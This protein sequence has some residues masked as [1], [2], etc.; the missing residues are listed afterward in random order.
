[1]KDL[2]ITGK[3]L[4]KNT[5]LNFFGQALPALVGLITL[6][7]IIKGLG[8][9]RFGVFSLAWV[10][11]GY[12]TIFD[13][14]LG[15]ATTK[16]VAEAL[17]KGEAKLVPDIV[18][19]AAITQAIFGVLGSLV[20]A[21]TTPLLVDQILSIP[22]DLTQEA[23]HAFYVVALIVPLILISNSFSGALDASQRFDLV[24]IVRLPSSTLTFILP[25][26]GTFLGFKLPGVFLLILLLRILTLSALVTFNYR[27]FPNFSQFS[28]SMQ[29]FSKLFTFGRWMLVSIVVGPILV[30][31]DRFFIGSLVSITAV[32]YYTVPYEAVTRLWI[33]PASL[34]MTLFPAFGALHGIKDRKNLEILLL[35]S[36]QYVLLC[37][38]PVV[39]V[40]VLYAREILEI[41][42]GSEFAARGTVAMQVLAVGVLVNSLA[43]AALA[44]LQG[45][46]R[47]DLTAK[48]HLL[49]LVF[50]V[51]TAWVL[52]GHWGVVGASVAWTLRVTLDTILL[53]V[54]VFKICR[55]SSSSILA[56][57]GMK[58]TILALLLL[59]TMACCLKMLAGSLPVFYQFCT[60][61][62]ILCIFAWMV[63]KHV[64]VIEDRRLLLNAF[65]K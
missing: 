9:A 61:I 62:S 51:G 33:I 4:T 29:T 22:P 19:N 17:G 6:P 26:V 37:L 43:H 27:I 34:S 53:F 24:N 56:T 58:T 55:F 40:I 47:P 45:I 3:T 41:W 23:K 5:I 8:T 57:S 1:M 28:L 14:G 2:D 44:L 64:L 13:L 49:E 50:Y 48:F 38:G 20:L 18:W 63:W 60:F 52:V 7:F 30:Y 10:V 35:R 31:L 12:L 46:G 59:T 32:A 21:G 42:V 15:R 39:L 11:L 25:L 54:A 36:V 16:F 65:K